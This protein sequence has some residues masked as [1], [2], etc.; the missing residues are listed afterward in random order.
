M[1]AK[2]ESLI[3]RG[4]KLVLIGSLEDELYSNLG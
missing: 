2:V 1:D 4:Q 3:N